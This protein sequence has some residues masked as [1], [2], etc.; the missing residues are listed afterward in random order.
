MH[1]KGLVSLQDLSLAGTPV[2]DEGLAHLKG[3]KKLTVLHLA[4]SL[5][6]PE[7]IADFKEAVPGC[8]VNKPF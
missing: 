6:T 2:S 8:K 7:G 5:V 4:G 1:L 3:L